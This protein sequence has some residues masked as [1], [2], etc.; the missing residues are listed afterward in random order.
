MIVLFNLVQHEL[1]IVK[2]SPYLVS[3]VTA[4]SCVTV[5]TRVKMTRIG[6]VDLVRMTR[7]SGIYLFILFLP[8]HLLLLIFL[9]SE[10]SNIIRVVSRFPVH[11]I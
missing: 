8:S 6:H 7:H 1:P 5:I 10:E 11:S 9:I 2:R 3:K 4:N